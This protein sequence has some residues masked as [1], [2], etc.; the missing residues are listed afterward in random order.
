M[1]FLKVIEIIRPPFVSMENVP[2]LAMK[3]KI[4]DAKETNKSYLQ[5]VMGTLVSLGY[6]VSCTFM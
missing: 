2:G 6:N 1:D 3:R 4:N 5:N